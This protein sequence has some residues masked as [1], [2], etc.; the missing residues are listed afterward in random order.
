[1]LRQSLGFLLLTLALCSADV[2]Q[3][4]PPARE[5]KKCQFP[6]QVWNDCGSACPMN[7]QRLR[8]DDGVC[9]MNCVPGCYCVSPYIFKSGTSGPCTLPTNCPK[10]VSRPVKGRS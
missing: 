3:R 8:H 9:T 10:K 4:Q 5:G 6:N 7:C 2:K 1:M